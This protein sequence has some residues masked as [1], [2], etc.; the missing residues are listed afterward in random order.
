LKAE[1]TVFAKAAGFEAAVAAVATAC[2]RL[3]WRLGL[4][5]FAA[6]PGANASRFNSSSHGSSKDIFMSK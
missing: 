3:R 4:S 6:Q 2:T 5:N 1:E